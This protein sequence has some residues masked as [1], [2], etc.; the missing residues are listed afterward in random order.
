MSN[1]N[2]KNPAGSNEQPKVE[3]VKTAAIGTRRLKIQGLR[4]HYGSAFFGNDF[5]SEKPVGEPLETELRQ[6][7]GK[8]VKT[9]EDE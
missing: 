6:L 9:V 5:V 3:G 7:F 1:T 8:A 2:D 4:G